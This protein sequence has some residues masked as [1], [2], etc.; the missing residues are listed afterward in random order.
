MGGINAGLTINE[1]I[2]TVFG[3]MRIPTAPDLS[4]Y[5]TLGA[6]VINFNGSLDL[7]VPVVGFSRTHHRIPKTD[8][9]DAISIPFARCAG[10]KA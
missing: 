7:S 5:G 8:L 3:G 9:W 4:L 2:A 6:R 1:T 10:V